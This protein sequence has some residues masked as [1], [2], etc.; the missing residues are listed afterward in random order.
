MP[1]PGDTISHY[2]LISAI[3]KGG[4]GEVYLAE[5]TRLDRRVAIKI[6]LDDV[7]GDVDRVRRF[8]QEAKA[9]SALNHPNILTVFE[10][11]EH[12]HSRY[13]ATELIEGET[14]R[15]LMR[16][17]G[18]D[19]RTAI[20]IAVQVATA[21]AAAHESGILHRD[22][23]PE[24]VMVR[25][26]GLVKVLDFG[27][28]KLLEQDLPPPSEE[29]AT[30][31]RID[32][33]P[34]LLIGTL[35]YMSPE[36]VRS[37]KLDAR[38]DIFSLGTVMYEL[39]SGTFPFKGDGHLEIASSVLKDDPAPLREISPNLPPQ[40]ERIVGKALRKDREHRYQ[41]IKDLKID[42]EDLQDELRFEA[43]QA[44]TA[45]RRVPA[46][47][48]E[49]VSLSETIST[50]RRFTLL[51]AIIFVAVAAAIVGAVWFLRPASAPASANYKMTEVASWNSAP[52]EL[53]S[54][55][56][57]SPDGKM[58]AFASTKSG[59]KNIWVTQVNSTA[60]IQVTNDEFANTDPI[61]S[62]KGDEIAYLALGRR[63]G[64]VSGIWRVPALG[65][66][67]RLIA[68]IPSGSLIRRWTQSGKIYYKLNNEFYAVDIASGASQKVTSFDTG[69]IAWI[70]VSPD[71]KSI[72]FALQTKDTWQIAISDLS[73]ERSTEVAKGAGTMGTTAA[74]LPEKK[75]LFYTA[76]VDGVLQS[77]VTNVGSAQSSQLTSAE[78]D[79]SVVDAS[80]DGT[81]I[82]VTSAKEESNIWRVGV[83][84]G[85]EEYVSR[86]INT[87]IFPAVA[88]ANDK[89]VFQSAKNLGQ[90]NNLFE[91]AIVVKA[92]TP[93]T[94]ADR[95][96]QLAERGF[97][98][99]WSP[100]GTSVA[101]LRRKDSAYELAVVN[102]NG[103]NERTL[104]SGVFSSGY[105]TSPYNC[106][107]VQVFAWA[108][109]GSRIAYASKES[110][111]A[112]MWFADSRGGAAVMV[113][114]NVD[115]AVSLSC[116]VWSP[117]GKRLAFNFAKRSDDIAG[118]RYLDSESKRV[119]DVYETK[120]ASRLIG[121][122]PDGS[123]LI[124]AERERTSGSGLPPETI[125]KR[126]GVDTHAET[127]LAT[128][129]N[130]YFYNIFVSDDRKFIAYAA[131]NDD[132]DDLWLIPSAGGAA[133]KLTANNDKGLYY[134]RLAWLHD[135]SAIVFGKQTRF[136]LLSMITD[137]D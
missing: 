66:P 56:R 69:Q 124:V 72:A 40:L 49:R 2:R 17:G 131:R 12:H 100:D 16:E 123:G 127:V 126:I 68:S 65:G 36:Q 51:H 22:I 132:K 39:F 137:I 114:D 1:G 105:S 3:G 58:I 18:M 9:A 35:A 80:P 54:S 14:L 101:F 28:A 99:A 26:D 107:D 13:I 93:R 115:P 117:D 29:A 34:G 109:D 43:K 61:Y 41:H 79:T 118:L 81:S 57:F 94:E 11:G 84:D 27:L 62:P 15:N 91:T 73:G 82:I 10:I 52:G 121:W 77:F 136:S 64:N 44:L 133:R 75:R 23:K 8:I 90:G 53:Y 120:G 31:A 48:T 92:L 102:G 74:W 85:H 63:T 6:L 83:R 76:S 37:Q 32:T 5:D 78:T 24:N 103:A 25:A 4:M 86:D 47:T 116:P 71:E 96:V 70:D 59:A 38:T 97:L 108:S 104:A 60:A 87:K 129:K 110:G 89:V 50:T 88:P 67:P 135:G 33:Q 125:L 7:A 119:T 134:S 21:L 45:E 30:L 111:A 112:N 98:P 20:N 122:T 46:A 106:T 113:T 128:L 130:A 95:P 55:A 42:L 19:L